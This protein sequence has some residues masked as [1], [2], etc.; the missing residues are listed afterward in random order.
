MKRTATILFF[1]GLFIEV[2]AFFGDHAANIQFVMKLVAP[3]YVQAQSGIQILSNKK[4]LEFKDPG[5]AV[6]ADIFMAELREQNAPK[7][8][9]GISIIGISRANA[10]M[11]F[12][13]N[14]AKEVIPIKFSLSNGQ[15]LDWDLEFLVTRIDK[16][17][18]RNIFCYAIIVFFVGAFI[19]CIGFVIESRKCKHRRVTDTGTA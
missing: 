4:K 9:D 7:A 15:T 3:K 5:F 8:V 11:N 14:R 18:N 13:P 16:L 1:L 17:Q 19:Q 12:S 6:I 10:F 2:A